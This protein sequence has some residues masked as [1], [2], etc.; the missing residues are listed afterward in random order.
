MN[1]EFEC[2]LFIIKVSLMKASPV[3]TYSQTENIFNNMY[4]NSF[5]FQHLL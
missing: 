4:P 1:E 5:L 2:I 3:K